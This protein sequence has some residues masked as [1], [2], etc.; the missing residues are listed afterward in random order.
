M[1]N[2]VTYKP[3]NAGRNYK[4]SEISALNETAFIGKVG[5]GPPHSLYLIVYGGI[6]LASNPQKIWS[7]VQTLIVDRFVD[8]EI[9]VVEKE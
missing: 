1:V 2:T 6:V 3:K 5:N 7:A 8:L 9:F 4:F